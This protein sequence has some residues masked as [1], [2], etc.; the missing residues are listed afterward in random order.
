MNWRLKP[1]HG[2]QARRPAS[3]AVAAH[4]LGRRLR[5]SRGRPADPG[6]RRFGHL[7]IVTGY[8]K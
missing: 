2:A 3:G 5:F 4:A 8:D 6:S 1:C 7:F